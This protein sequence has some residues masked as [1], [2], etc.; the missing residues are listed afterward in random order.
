MPLA[1]QDRI[2]RHGNGL[3]EDHVALNQT[4]RQTTSA[5][6]VLSTNKKTPGESF[7]EFPNQD[8]FLGVRHMP[9]WWN[10]SSMFR[11]SVI[12]DSQSEQAP[13]IGPKT[14]AQF[15]GEQLRLLAQ[16]TKVRRTADVPFVPVS[17]A[18]GFSGD[19]PWI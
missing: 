18:E 17:K 13:A 11:P 1:L 5:A 10:L 2:R 12:A 3:A 19:R 14:L 4:T 6:T 7:A 8:V 16:I 15:D 9:P